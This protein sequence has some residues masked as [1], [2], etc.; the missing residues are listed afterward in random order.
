M[1]IPHV[2]AAAVGQHCSD[3]RAETVLTQTWGIFLQTGAGMQTGFGAVRTG[4]R[5]SSALNLQSSFIQG[6]RSG[7]AAQKAASTARSHSPSTAHLCP[8]EGMRSPLYWGETQQKEN[9]S[10]ATSLPRSS[11]PQSYAE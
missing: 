11:H 5:A 7:G 1:K 6:Q 10:K 8:A 2:S 3:C 9:H 4:P